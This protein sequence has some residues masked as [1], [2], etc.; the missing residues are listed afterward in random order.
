[1]LTCSQDAL[2]DEL[3]EETIDVMRSLKKALDPKSVIPYLALNASADMMA[4]G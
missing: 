2:M 4:D 3:G 1:M